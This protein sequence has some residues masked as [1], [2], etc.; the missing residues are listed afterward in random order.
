MNRVTSHAFY[1]WNFLP[2]PLFQ[3][4]PRTAGGGAVTATLGK[5]GLT[6]TL[7]RKFSL[8]SLRAARGFDFYSEMRKRRLRDQKK[9]HAK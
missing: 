1:A 8:W 7:C 3:R 2:G 5:A 4:T 6:G 9:V